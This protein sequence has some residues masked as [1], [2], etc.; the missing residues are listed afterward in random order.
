MVL[1]QNYCHDINCSV[2]FISTQELTTIIIISILRR[3]T[4]KK[5]YHY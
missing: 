4:W 1:R 5:Y 3:M 2:L